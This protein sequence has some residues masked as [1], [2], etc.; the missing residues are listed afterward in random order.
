MTEPKP[1][2]VYINHQDIMREQIECTYLRVVGGVV[3]FL[4][5]LT[6]IVYLLT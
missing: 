5:M 2:R 3:A 4:S 6:A 1:E